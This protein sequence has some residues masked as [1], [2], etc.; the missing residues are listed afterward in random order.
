MQ[1]DAEGILTARV[2]GCE[3]ERPL[4]QDSVSQDTEYLSTLLETS[5][6]KSNSLRGCLLPEGGA[7]SRGGTSF[8]KGTQFSVELSILTLSLRG[9]S[10]QQFCHR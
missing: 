3:A 5:V 7:I 6:F 2:D 9:L 8:R 4:S 10:E 1:K